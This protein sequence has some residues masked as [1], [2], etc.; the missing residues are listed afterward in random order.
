MNRK[1]S[2]LLLIILIQVLVLMGIEP[3]AEAG[4]FGFGGDSWREEVLLHDGSKMIITRSQTYGGSHEIGQPLPIKEHTITFTLPGSPTRITW[5]S[6][7][8][9]SLGRTDFTPLALHVLNNTPYIIVTPNLMLSYHK[10]GRPNPPYVFFKYEDSKWKRIAIEEVPPEFQTI[11]LVIDTLT[12]GKKLNSQGVASLEMIAKLNSSLT[13]EEYKTIHRTPLD[14]WKPR[15]NS[16]RMIR[17]E[18]GGWLG[19]DWFS[20]QPSLEACLKKCARENVSP[21]DCPCHALFK[22]K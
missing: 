20:S 1:R 9:E 12:D 19:L 14:H 15:G 16:G 18:D 3:K 5:I 21:K 17:T 7:Y 6:E 10:W 22:E 4:L 2:A 8:D 11:N 13:Q